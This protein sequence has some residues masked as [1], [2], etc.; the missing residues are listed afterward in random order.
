MEHGLALE[1]GGSV[2]DRAGHRQR[3]G[4]QRR[5]ASPIRSRA[6]RFR[7]R[8]YAIRSAAERQLA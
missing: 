7:E 4:R 1:L 8:V 6:P 3:R 2:R 5:P